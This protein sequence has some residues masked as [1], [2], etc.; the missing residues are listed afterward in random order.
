MKNLV[1]NKPEYLNLLI[2][3]IFDHHYHIPPPPLPPQG[4]LF[5]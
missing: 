1:T 2:F 4:F 3:D 5:I